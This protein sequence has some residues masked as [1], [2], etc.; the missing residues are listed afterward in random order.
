MHFFI[1]DV[2]KST[3]LMATALAGAAQ[4]GPPPARAQT[5]ITAT[6]FAFEAPD[7]VRA[8]L[9]TFRLE[10]QG[11]STHQVVLLRL[12][13][14]RTLRELER[15]L[16]TTGRLPKWAVDVGGPGATIPG[17]TNEV[18]IAVEPGRH[19]LLC[20]VRT[21]D[22]TLALMRGMYRA[23]EV[24]GPAAPVEPP[25]GD[26]TVLMSS[27]AVAIRGAIRAGSS[28]IRVRNG[29]SA[30]RELRIYPV[31]GANVERRLQSWLASEQGPPPADPVAGV[32]A[33]PPGGWAV[34]GVT[35]PRG[36]YMLVSRAPALRR[37]AFGPSKVIVQRV[38]IR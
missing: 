28:R 26:V 8:G 19:V 5:L 10:N 37:P 23:M 14:G 7:T 11:L 30:S 20:A 13:D 32:T 35:L 31:R 3:V 36:E 25:A 34:L 22:G 15:E 1:L 18:V 24:V 27:Q 17:S 4:G 33:L 6:D 38:R 29:T 16:V 9:V 12:E 2:L 21:A